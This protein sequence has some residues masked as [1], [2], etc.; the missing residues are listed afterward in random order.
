MIF[1]IFNLVVEDPTA[2]LLGK[3]ATPQAMAALSHKLGLDR[4]W[5]IQYWDIFKSAFTFNFGYAWSSKQHILTLFQKGALV[6]LT[7]TFPAFLIG[8]VLVISVAL[9]M[10]KYR[11]TIWDKLLV[12]F[13]ITMTS[14]SVLV[15]ILIGQG[16]FAYK[17]DLFEITGYESGLASIPYIILPTIIQVWL[18]FCYYYRF[19]RTVMLDEIYQDYVR[20]IRAKGLKERIVLFKHVLKN[21]MVPI[22][23]TLVADMPSL[24]FGSV[25]I[26]N[27]FCIPGL[28]NVVMNA[29]H[30]CD[31]P[32][33]QAATVVAAVLSVLFNIIGDI[34]YTLVDP[35]IKL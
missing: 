15:Y 5:Y 3:Y 27:F 35:R 24:I 20:T 10:T 25:L 8:N 34:L 32:T 2:I 12:T 28:G 17:L 33:I 23:T 14:I 26:E 7:V 1:I 21:V 4:A 16:L 18:H 13:C 29:I 19:Y 9:W 11:E 22:I 6:S 30:C 31:F